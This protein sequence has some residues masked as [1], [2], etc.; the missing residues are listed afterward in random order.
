VG[1]HA[2]WN[3]GRGRLPVSAHLTPAPRARGQSWK[4]NKGSGS[5]RLLNLDLDRQI[6]GVAGRK[7]F[8]LADGGLDRQQEAACLA[9][10]KQGG[11]PGRTADR[12]L[13]LYRPEAAPGTARH[14]PD[15]RG[16][17]LGQ[18]GEEA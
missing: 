9:V 1:A 2:R 4:G 5:G 18:G 16:Q 17:V 7:A 10:G 15:R 11:A 6:D 14:G 13:H 12:G 3:V 8:T